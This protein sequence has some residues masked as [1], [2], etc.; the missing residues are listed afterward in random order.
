MHL[1]KRSFLRRRWK[2]SALAALAV[3]GA[4]GLGA[5]RWLSP[6]APRAFELSLVPAADTDFALVLYQ[7][8]GARLVPGHA[9]KLLPNGTVFDALV[10]QVQGAKSTI[11]VLMYIWEKG[12]ASDRVVSALIARAKAGVRCRIVVDD[13]GSPDFAKSVQ[14][15]LTQA[16]C[17]V[18][19]FRPLSGSD[20][21]ARNH[22]KL[23]V[24]DGTSAL[25]GGFGIR[26]NW[27]G[28]GIH[29][30][31]WR[32][33]NLL[34]AGPAVI[35]AQQL[36]AENWQEAG[37]ALLPREAFPASLASL[38][39]RAAFIGSSQ[40]VITRAER[41]T[42]LMI[43]TAQRRLWIANAYFVPSSGILELL[44]KKAKAGVDV[45]ILAPYKNSDSKTAFGA[46]HIEYGDLLKH[47]VKV[48]EYTSS[49]MHAK[50]M[51][52]DD[53]LALVGSINLDPLSLN[54]L[55]EDA[56]VVQDRPFADQLAAAF[57]ADCAR[58]KALSR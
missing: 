10:E 44:L 49:M 21:L 35:D 22:R 37:G 8:L 3:V 1:S 46:Q 38:G 54:E 42:Q 51:V 30:G 58:S 23:V 14:P 48:W 4:G 33:T 34:F 55:E 27:L 11:H 7:S 28:D 5:H 41:L 15:A 57:S 39:A 20:K 56:L 26:D 2:A 50:T 32:D 17:D 13:L 43:A 19:I 25:I 40:G 52:V 6:P 12:A 36:F 31:S 24:V 47:G 45:R 53:E 18:R 29:A 9:L 16:G